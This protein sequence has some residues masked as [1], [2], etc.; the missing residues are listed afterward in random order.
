MSA[1]LAGIVLRRQ[2]GEFVEVGQLGQRAGRIR[3]THRLI[4]GHPLA[5]TPAQVWAGRAQRTLQP[6][7]FLGQAGVAQRLVHQPG[8]L[9]ALLRGQRVQ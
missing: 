5:A 1:R 7:H 2:L 8:Q 9:C 3:V 4:A 6:A